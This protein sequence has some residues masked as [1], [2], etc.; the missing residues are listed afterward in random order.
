MEIEQE[1][2]IKA[3]QK[4]SRELLV[5]IEK[6]NE[7]SKPSQSIIDIPKST[8]TSPVPVSIPVVAS[9]PSSP[10]SSIEGM[11]SSENKA[12]DAGLLIAFPVIVATLGFFFFF[13]FLRENLAS[14]LPPLPSV[15]E[16]M[17]NN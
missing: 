8:A 12:F 9:T 1:N 4:A 11:S 3:L 6:S 17:S 16:M 10:S 14:S 7:I 2:N 13:P 5:K 15:E